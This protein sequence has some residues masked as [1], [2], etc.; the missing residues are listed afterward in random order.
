M[1]KTQA[2][3]GEVTSDSVTGGPDPRHEVLLDAPTNAEQVIEREHTYVKGWTLYML[4][5]GRIWILLFLPTLETTIV[6]T[7]LV[8][9][10][11]SLSGFELRN[12]VVTAYFLTYTGFLIIY[13]KLATIFG[14]KTMFLLALTLFT[15]FLIAYGCA[16]SMTQLI[17]LRAFQGIGGSG[18][19][20]MVLAIAPKLVPQTEYGK[21]VGIISSVFALAS[22]SGPLAGG[23]M[24]SD[25]TWRWVFLLNG[26]PGVLSIVIIAI[27]M[28]SSQVD[29]SSSLARRLRAKLSREST[30]RVDFSGAFSLL[31]AFLLVFALESGGSQYPWDSGTIVS[32]LVLCGVL[33]V[34]FVAWEI[35]LGRTKAT[36]EPIFPMAVYG[37]SPARA[38]LSVL[39][40]LLKLPAATAA[41]GVLT[42]NVNIPPSHLI[43]LGSVIQLTGAGLAIKIPLTGDHIS[44]Q[45]YGSEAVM[46]VGFWFDVEYSVVMGALTQT[47]VL[48]GT[49]ALAICSAILGN[50]LKE[51]LGGVITQAGFQT[52][53]ETLG[54]INLPGPEQATKVKHAFAEGYNKQFRLLAGF[55]GAALL[56]ALFLFSREPLTGF[57][58]RHR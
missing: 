23:A 47:R 20:S 52:I 11:D 48:G 41:S 32:I 22:I 30:R 6:S 12:W 4:T 58:A 17:I 19:Y 21:Y 42:S 33:W 18:I 50:H 43:L 1:G 35:Y 24:S 28:P 27:F 14:S 51:S 10:A 15:V 40:L 26:P 34:A 29:S 44:A 46:G 45:Q 53:G 55:S 13:A 31:S 2:G 25:T 38:S 8:A 39:P 56:A 5:L 49:V 37:L 3:D 9:I 54:A 36:K 7:S 57:H 16:S